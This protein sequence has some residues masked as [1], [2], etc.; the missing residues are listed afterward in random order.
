MQLF[1]GLKLPDGLHHLSSQTAFVTKPRE[2]AM[3]AIVFTD[4]CRMSVMRLRSFTEGIQ[5][6]IW[7]FGRFATSVIKTTKRR[8]SEKTIEEDMCEDELWSEL[9]D[10]RLGIYEMRSV[11]RPKGREGTADLAVEIEVEDVDVAAGTEA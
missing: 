5:K 3:T 9:C 7:K 4:Q 6:I 11:S 1:F 8:R 10:A 2:F